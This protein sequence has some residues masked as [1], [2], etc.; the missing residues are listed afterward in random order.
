ME[1]PVEG[2][3][4]GD[5]ALEGAFPEKVAR[6]T[7]NIEDPLE[8]RSAGDMERRGGPAQRMFLPPTALDRRFLSRVASFRRF[9]ARATRTSWLP[10]AS[11]RPSGFNW[12]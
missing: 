6:G 3:E 2:V 4:E 1:A 5:P 8:G 10:R 12:T 11:L 7:K 9:S